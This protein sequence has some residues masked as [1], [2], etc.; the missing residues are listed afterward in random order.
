[1][2]VNI[3]TKTPFR[4]KLVALAIASSVSS[5]YAFNFETG[6][7][8]L[9][10]SLDNTIKYSTAFRV[11]DASA[12]LTDGDSNKNQNDGD[13]NF[14][15]G[16]VSNRLDLLTQFDASYK[17]RFGVR[18]TGAAWY[19]DV[20]HGS[21]DNDNVDGTSNHTPAKEFSDKAEEVMGGDA[22]ILDA[23]VYAR[24]PFV[25]G[26]E[27]TIRVGRH[28]LLW[29]ESLFYGSNGIAGGQGPVD[30]VKLTSVP[31]SQFKETLRPT[32]KVSVDVP[33]SESLSLG[34]YVGYE[35]EKS[36]LLPAGA[37]LS[38]GDALEGERINT[39]GP[40]A[41]IN[42]HD[43]DAS[44]SGQYGI[45]LRY[46]DFNTETDYGLYA[47]RYHAAGP[48]NN[49]F[50]PT[51]PGQGTY[52]WVFAEN[53]EAY[54]FSVAKTVGRWS[55]A[56]EVSYRRNTPLASKGQT[57]DVPNQYDN[58]KNPGYAVGET[59]HAQFSW[60]ANVPT[61][62]AQEASF[63]G[64]IA[65]NTRLKTTENED[66]LNTNADKSAIGMRLVYR[67]TYRQVFD[68]LDLTPSIGISRTWG[69]SSAVG[70]A[71]GVDGGGDINIG[72][73]ALYLNKW[74]ASLN[75]VSYYGPKGAFLD[76]EGSPPKAQYK[77]ALKDRNFI[78]ASISTTF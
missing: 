46:S 45:Q 78:S 29:G 74:N 33:L 26:M 72:V 57:F 39:F 24:F 40:F 13:N 67:P 32:G 44:D 21:T 53:I 55:L 75:F 63:I 9:R 20:Y 65:W 52:R 25:D 5:A 37:F 60:I 12:A 15:K 22:E 42:E 69:K 64:E 30:V 35:W 41:F 34:A 19:D 59:A 61:F 38:A 14:D 71:F 11:K 17:D 62:I 36:R 6:N 10:I 8:D 68:G 48:S 16:M 58:N 31:N 18:V 56:G 66:M 7:P 54:G 50:M 43:M 77:Q 70:P 27:G 73:N 23:F 51:G 47:T 49:Y 2:Q 4:L 3:M 1:M 76:D 28:T